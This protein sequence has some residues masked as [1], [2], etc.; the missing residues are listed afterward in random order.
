[1]IA[2]L[3]RFDPPRATRWLMAIVC[4]LLAVRAGIMLID[5]VDVEYRSIPFSP[6]SERV[7][8]L[9][10]T[11]W[12]MFGDPSETDYGFA[13]VLP[14]TPLSLRL[15]GVVTGER[16]Y[17]IIVDAEGS[18]GVYRVDDEVPGGAV[19]VAIEPRRVVFSR[20]GGREALELPG[21]SQSRSAGR[22]TPERSRDN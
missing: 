5:G 1:M 8:A 17:A 9:P 18:E 6:S 14:A 4:V 21:S 19:V 12:R 7:G 10:A 22:S 20:A 3:N 11:D 16:G 13:Q 15:R 2:S